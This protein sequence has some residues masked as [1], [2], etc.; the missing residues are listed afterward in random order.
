MHSARRCSSS[1]G[2]AL[3]PGAELLIPLA[4][5]EDQPGDLVRERARRIPAVEVPAEVLQ[6]NQRHLA[7]AGLAVGVLDAVWW[8]P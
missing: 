1:A 4:G 7:V 6:Q 5:V 3:V 8:G 2:T